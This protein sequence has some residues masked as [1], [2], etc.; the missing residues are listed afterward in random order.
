MFVSLTLSL[1][2][3]LLWN[4]GVPLQTVAQSLPGTLFMTWL[5]KQISASDGLI[6]L[7]A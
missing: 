2:L 6:G 1:S 7:A 5:L 4:S 3:S